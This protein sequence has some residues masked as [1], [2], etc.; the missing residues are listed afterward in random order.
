M[1]YNQA[2][3]QRSFDVIPDGTIVVVQ[4]NIRAGNVGEGGILKR[5]NNG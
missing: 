2:G 3:A 5:S 1:D 4:M